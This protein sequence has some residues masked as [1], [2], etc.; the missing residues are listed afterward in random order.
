MWQRIRT[1]PD[2]QFV[3]L[4]L[5]IATAMQ[6]LK[7]VGIACE[8]VTSP[9]AFGKGKEDAYS[10]AVLEASL[11]V[12]RNEIYGLA[13]ESSCGKSTFI[14]TIAAAIRPPLNVVAGTV[15]YSF[16]D[17]DIYALEP[18][19]LNRIRWRHFSYI[20]QGSMNVL[21]PVR[22][23]RQSKFQSLPVAMAS[24]NLASTAARS[25]GST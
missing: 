21:N 9:G 5:L 1:S 2:W 22:R 25:S 14:K 12:N 4:N 23:I 13:G 16:L 10:R 18:A 11:Q 6:L 8:G 24:P 7:N 20:M 19:E 15:E 3:G 17:R